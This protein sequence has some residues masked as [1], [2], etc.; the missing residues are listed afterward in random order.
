M[1]RSDRLF[2]CR[3][4]QGNGCRFLATWKCPEGT[5]F[6][7]EA[8]QIE[9]ERSDT[10]QI[11]GEKRKRDELDR[12]SVAWLQMINSPAFAVR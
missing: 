6:A 12:R 10:Q 3:I 5:W 11:S 9:R 7:G 2:F 4:E 1:I 8:Q